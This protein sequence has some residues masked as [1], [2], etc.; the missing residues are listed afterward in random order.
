MPNKSHDNAAHKALN[1]MKRDDIKHKSHVDFE[2]PASTRQ[3]L[4]IDDCLHVLK[5]LPDGCVQLILLDRRTT[6]TF[7]CGTRTAIT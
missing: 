6:S 2:V 1:A 7:P 4:I 5:K 3:A